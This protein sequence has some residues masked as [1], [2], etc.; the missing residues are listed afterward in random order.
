MAALLCSLWAEKMRDGTQTRSWTPDPQLNNLLGLSGSRVTLS[1]FAPTEKAKVGHPWAELL[2]D[3]S[4][5]IAQDCNTKPNIWVR[6]WPRT[7]LLYIHRG[8]KQY[9]IW[10]R[11]AVIFIV[12]TVIK[13]LTVL[14]WQLDK[15][16]YVI[17]TLCVS[18]FHFRVIQAVHLYLCYGGETFEGQ[19][20][21]WGISSLLGFHYWGHLLFNA[22]LTQNRAHQLKFENIWLIF[23][24]CL[25]SVSE[26]ANPSGTPP[27][28]C[29]AMKSD[30][31]FQWQI[32]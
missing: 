21:G 31:R 22:D 17:T 6:L 15:N 8:E 27:V 4:D 18:S 25:A 19:I 23:N 7:L 13:G 12:L 10:K 5:A 11:P 2:H 29:S 32:T 1:K 16:I 26:A 9:R 14:L 3:I 24:V 28:L 30:H 20:T